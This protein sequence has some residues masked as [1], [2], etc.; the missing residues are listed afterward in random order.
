MIYVDLSA[1]RT[2]DGGYKLI[3]EAKLRYWVT[4]PGDEIAKE[5]VGGTNRPSHYNTLL[6]AALNMM[7]RME[8]AYFF[9]LFDC[10]HQARRAIREGKDDEARN[11]IN[12]AMGKVDFRYKDKAL[13]SV[14]GSLGLKD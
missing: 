8:E 12:S 3:G 5:T 1:E 9:E 13:E 6:H 7:G 11:W 14:L 2:E 4:I 10:L